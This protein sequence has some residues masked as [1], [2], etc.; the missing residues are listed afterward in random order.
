MLSLAPGFSSR[1]RPPKSSPPSN[2]SKVS[3]EWRSSF[4]R[5]TYATIKPMPGE[6]LPAVF[7]RLSTLLD[8]AAIVHMFLY[9]C[10]GISA[11]AADPMRRALGEICWPITSVE[12]AACD[13]HPLAG[14]QVF[15]VDEGAV[16]RIQ[17]DGQNVGSVFEDGATKHCL[18][19]GLLPT[20]RFSSRSDQT[21]QA[22]EVLEASLVQAG[23]AIADTA[24]TWFFLDDILSWYK[25]FNEARTEVYSG[26]KFRTHSLPASTGVGAS[27]PAGAAL[28]LAAW[29][30][31][32]EHPGTG[33]R[34]IASPLQ[35]PA[36]AYGSSFSRASEYPSAAGRHLLISGTASIALQGETLWK[37]DVH[38]Q[39]EETMRV[40]EA[41]VQSR[42]GSLRDLTRA[43][44]YFKHSGDAGVFR[45]WCAARD[46]HSLVAVPAKCDICRDALLFEFEGE[47]ALPHQAQAKP[48]NG[49]LAK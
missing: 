20:Q 31:Q 25:Q 24:R 2:R 48:G 10:P 12:G 26:I 9:G 34:E 35:C 28:T 43:T 37:N 18:M 5:Q 30:M 7:D 39:V 1:T 15:G 22:L 47:A 40:V 42:C 13:S 19:G 16:Q 46:L 27:N 41:I 14:I 38:R 21:K 49:Y 4:G 44:A 33:A 6:A 32:S 45:E 8:G 17:L 3:Y 36:P 11:A 23:F 29:A